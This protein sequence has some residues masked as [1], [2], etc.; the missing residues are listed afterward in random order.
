M[1]R[2]Q[3]LLFIIFSGPN[4]K[5]EA[6]VCPSQNFGHTRPFRTID[7]GWLKQTS[8]LLKTTVTKNKSLFFMTVEIISRHYKN[9]RC[10]HKSFSTSGV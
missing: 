1:R 7:V 2:L 3:K 4:L 8:R 5:N 9:A 10:H 6:A